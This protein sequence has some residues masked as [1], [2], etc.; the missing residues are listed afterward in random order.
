M[1]ELEVFTIVCLYNN[2]SDPLYDYAEVADNVP[3]AKKIMKQQGFEKYM[4]LACAES[5]GGASFFGYGITEK[6]AIHALNEQLKEYDYKAVV[7]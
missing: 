5:D 6:Q 4:W 1:Q 3:C 7:L 2:E